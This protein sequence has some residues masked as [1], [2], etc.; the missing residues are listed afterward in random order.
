MTSERE[1]CGL[2]SI[3]PMSCRGRAEAFA[4]RLQSRLQTLGR[5]GSG[6]DESADES[7]WIGRQSSVTSC[8]P[9]LS[10][11]S[12]SDIFFDFDLDTSGSP[13]E[14]VP[15]SSTSRNQCPH[16]VDSGSVLSLST[17][18]RTSP[19]SDESSDERYFD[20]EYSDCE[21]SRSEVSSDCKH[22]HA[23]PVTSEGNKASTFAMLCNG[24]IA[25]SPTEYSNL[26]TNNEHC[27]T[28]RHNKINVSKF[29][30][31]HTK[32]KN[33]GINY[34]TQNI[35][36]DDTTED[37]L[38]SK[39][40]VLVTE[41]VGKEIENVVPEESTRKTDDPSQSS[42][43]QENTD[44]VAAEKHD[45][46]KSGS[47]YSTEVTGDTDVH[48]LPDLSVCVC[49]TINPENLSSESDQVCE[50]STLVSTI[51]DNDI[52]ISQNDH[53]LESNLQCCSSFHRPKNLLIDCAILASDLEQLSVLVPLRIDMVENNSSE[54]A[55]E[56]ESDPTVD[57]E[58]QGHTDDDADDVDER[59]RRIRRS[60]SLKSGKTPPGTPGR[61]KIVRFAD[62]LGL[63]LADVRTFLDD[64]PWVPQSAYQDLQ[65][66][67]LSDTA[68]V[69]VQS[70]G[71]DSFS[72]CAR[73]TDKC[74]VP[75][76]Q[77]PGNHVDFLDK[78]RERQ[79]CLE[80]ALVTDTIFFTIT[81]YV[82][83]RNLDF[84][85]SVYIR[86]TLDGW[87]TFSDLQASYIDGSCDGFSDRFSFKLYAHTV[88]IG[89]K[90][91]F[92]I[93][94]Q[95]KGVQYWDSNLGANYTFQ[96][97]PPIA[98]TTTSLPLASPVDTWPASFY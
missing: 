24:H 79:V 67:D 28:E 33:D 74:L 13:E 29:E 71:T 4:R 94:F 87:K 31:L 11:S 98:P 93:R 86:Y 62:V 58:S 55:E 72:V 27:L 51:F 57:V 59:P 32:E 66:V 52:C 96:C 36:K 89:S 7:S 22:K 14:E 1:T 43:T 90:V 21:T 15:P 40:H 50:D 9:R 91:E 77:Q 19:I 78:V 84:H 81:G 41:S 5:S 64:I 68:S 48:T 30:D 45:N 97:L 53:E 6:L 16:G 49:P 88:N 69:P 10:S 2:G 20:P 34:C 23:S 92:A 35:S 3:I 85:K 95:C 37:P 76:F 54:K 73:R 75:M 39:D 12:D 38:P 46:S 42:K 80:S 83:V 18:E 82:R 47:K 61:K 17:T 44:I 60:S 63:D 26:R 8:Q 56:T 65:D 70:S 25:M